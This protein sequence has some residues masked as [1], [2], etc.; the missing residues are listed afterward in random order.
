[1]P[2]HLYH[3]CNGC[4]GSSSSGFSKPRIY[5]LKKKKK[6]KKLIIQVSYLGSENRETEFP[7]AMFSH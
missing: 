3:I 1:L 2:G 6:R 5:K 7:L 4:G